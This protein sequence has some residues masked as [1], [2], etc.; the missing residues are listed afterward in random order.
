MKKLFFTLVALLGITACNNDMPPKDPA[1][2]LKLEA[3]KL[4]IVANGEEK[5]TFTVTDA[6]NNEV[7]AT[8]LFADTNEALEGNTF[9]TKFAGEYIFIAK[10]IR[11]NEISNVISIKAVEPSEEPTPEPGICTLTLEV[12]KSSIDA[13]GVDVATFTTT[14]D[15]TIVEATIYN[16]ANDTALEGNTFKTTVEGTY[17]FYAVYDDGEVSNEVTVTA[18]KNV[19]DEKPITLEASADTIRANGI[20]NV[21][22]LVIQ[23]GANVTSSAT[24]FVNGSTMNGNKFATT[25]PGTY[26][27]YAT[28]G[29][30]TSNEVIIT[31][32]AVET[33]TSIVF[34]EGVT[35][36]SGWYDVNKKGAGDNGDINM[37][38]AAAASNIIQWWQDRYVAAGNTLPA[39]AINGVGT[40]TYGVYS[41]YELALM[42]VFHD[43]WDNSHG[44]NVEHAIPWYFEG[45]LYDGKYM[46]GKATPYTA[47]GYFKSV[48]SG[49]EPYIYRGYKSSLFPSEFPAMYTYCYENYWLWGDGSNLQGQ[50]RLAYVSDIIVETFERGMA[51]LTVSL[52]ANLGSN[53]HAVTL[54]GY[55]IDNAT[56]LLTRVWITDS[57]DLVS[58]PKTQKLH[59]YR[60]SVDSGKSHI[61]FE[62]DTRYGAIFLVSIHPCSGYQK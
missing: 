3:D 22:L 29:N 33:G 21:I 50:E 8:I 47:G 14:L 44:G 7:E 41:P 58:E 18:Q 60:V 6:N 49:I 30:Q 61:K 9:K 62:G 34:A 19:V 24:I 35:I 17:T 48:W 15:D 16:A 26:T 38:W 27:I 36:S 39:G 56:G 46:S 57:D 55:E 31:A 11:S 32:E 25:T 4:T 40:K 59:E 54:W 43:D 13:D 10:A 37:C 52:A 20:D 2:T 42:E 23:D 53:H 45:S 51:S 12:D 1:Q 28:K 5:A